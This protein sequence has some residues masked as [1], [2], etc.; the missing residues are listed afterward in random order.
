MP[1]VSEGPKTLGLPIA[2]RSSAGHVGAP[3]LAHLNFAIQASGWPSN[4]LCVTFPGSG[5]GSNTV[6]Q[7]FE[8]ILAGQCREIS[9]HSEGKLAPDLDVYVL[10]SARHSVRL[11]P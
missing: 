5:P 8:R 3:L 2:A 4:R 9:L 10:C 6:H 11:E 7:V 1:A